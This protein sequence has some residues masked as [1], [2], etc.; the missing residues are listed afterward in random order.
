MKKESRRM[1]LPGQA[2]YISDYIRVSAG[3]SL[4]GDG[5]RE[6]PAPAQSEE[7]GQLLRGKREREDESGRG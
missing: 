1:G 5:G 7:D 4:S 3:Q 6:A 2:W